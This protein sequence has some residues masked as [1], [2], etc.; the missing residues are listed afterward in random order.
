MLGVLNIMKFKFFLGGDDA[1][2]RRI[3]EV[4]TEAGIDI[5]DAGLSWGAKAS[6]YGTAAFEA[7]VEGGLT[8]VLVE[9]V[10]DC[11]VPLGTIVIDHH[12]EKS[13]E[14]ASLLQ[15]L[16]LVKITPSRWDMIVA[17]NDA[18]WYPCLMGWADVPGLGR[19]DP[20]A[21]PQELRAIR[22]AEARLSIDM[23]EEIDRALTAPVEMI[24]ALRIVRMAH[25][26]TGLVGD[27]LAIAAIEAGASSPADFPAY[28]VF[29]DDGEVNFSGDGQ[30]AAE[31]HATF[32]GGW[33]GG[34]G[35]GR[36]GE[37]AFWGGYPSHTEVEAFLRER[38]VTV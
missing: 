3:A 24:G 10:V 26:K 34:S 37:T 20:P 18:G 15:V 9:L 7:A 33:A 8:P 11:N 25:S 12:G 19:L 30:L 38:F 4:L 13:S 16:D 32:P 31:L 23:V 36:V 28:L 5:I 35:L 6:M 17:A 2:M 14:P 29:S 1:E 21:T 27:R 22:G